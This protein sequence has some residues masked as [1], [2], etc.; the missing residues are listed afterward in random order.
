VIEFD[1]GGVLMILIDLSN[2]DFSKYI[3]FHYVKSWINWWI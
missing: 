1:C 2:E 3:L